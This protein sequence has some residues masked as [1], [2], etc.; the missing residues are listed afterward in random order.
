MSAELVRIFVHTSC[1]LAQGR[2]IKRYHSE[3]S[4]NEPLSKFS[5]LLIDIQQC[6]VI[7]FV[8]CHEQVGLGQEVGMR[9]HQNGSYLQVY[10]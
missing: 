2:A 6:T 1:P 8:Q 5:F 7:C 3:D 4:T 10:D 9:A